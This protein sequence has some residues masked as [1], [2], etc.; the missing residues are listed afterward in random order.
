MSKRAL[1]FGVVLLLSADSLFGDDEVNFSD[2]AIL[3]E[4][5]FGLLPNELKDLF[6]NSSLYNVLDQVDLKS[7]KD[8][9]LLGHL[10]GGHVF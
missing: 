5:F 2:L 6:S 1:V 3:R 4:R 9:L 8:M 10:T 7:I